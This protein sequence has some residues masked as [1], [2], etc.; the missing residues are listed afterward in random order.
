MPYATSEEFRDAMAAPSRTITIHGTI[1]YPD[2]EFQALTSEHICS[3]KVTENAGT[4]FPIGSAAA[5][6][7]VMTLNNAEGEWEAGGSILG[8]HS[9]DGAEVCLRVSVAKDEDALE[10]DTTIDGGTPSAT[11]ADTCDGGSPST[12]VFIESDFIGVDFF[13]SSNLGVFVIEKIETQEHSTIATLNGSDRLAIDCLAAFDDDLTYPQTLAE[14]LQEACDQ[15]GI[16]LKSSTF[17]QSTVSI[18]TAPAWDE[19]ITCRDVMS[20]IAC[21]A[22]GIARIARDG[23]LEIVTLGADD[24]YTL[25]TTRYKTLTRKGVSW[26][27]LN[28][29]SVY[30]FGHPDADMAT[31]V[32]T[33]PNIPD[34]AF[35]AIGIKGNPI[36][37]YGSSALSTLMSGTLAAHIA[38]EF[39]GASIDWQGDPTLTCGDIVVVTD[40]DSTEVR[41]LITNQTLE[42]K[43]GFAMTSGEQLETNTKRDAATNYTKV[44]T[45]TGHLN[46]ANLEGNIYIKAGEKIRIESGGD[47]TILAGGN[48]NLRAG[49][50]SDSIGISNNEDDD[51]FVWAGAEDPKD[52][53]F[54]VKMDGT[55]TNVA[56]LFCLHFIDNADST[57]DLVC[58]IYIPS[59]MSSIDKCVL[60]VKFE[61]FRAY[62][63]GA[64]AGGSSERTSSTTDD[65]RTHE[66][67]LFIDDATLSTPTNGSHDHTGDGSHSHSIGSHDH[68]INAGH[69]AHD[70]AIYSHN[71]TVSLDDHIHDITYGIYEGTSCTAAS[72]YVDGD[73]QLSNKTASELSVDVSAWFNKTDGII[74]RDT[75]HSIWLRPNALCRLVANIYMKSTIISKV[76]G[77]L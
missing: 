5:S 72:L 41:V 17:T 29:V 15:A 2:G 57:H 55:I 21:C 42:F 34:D 33:D 20:F 53:P 59:D 69:S 11:F 70:H 77:T 24:S 35:N 47:M 28:A 39:A 54:S 30:E 27:P 37:A 22:G 36:L 12:T 45:T 75:W 1:E 18:P 50:G 3:A 38:T 60:E 46:A 67:N 26:G 25:D 56:N 73:L 71:H 62:S 49:T 31:R 7:L 61:N 23:K 64:A 9:L 68:G 13:W 58:D 16:T 10:F 74:T 51:Y 8:E 4:H 40:L 14:I 19:Q 44:F 76:A 48:F 32:A 63:T 66:F 6:S 43:S 52:A 65:L